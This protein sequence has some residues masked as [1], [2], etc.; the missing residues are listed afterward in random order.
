MNDS[1]AQTKLP[2]VGNQRVLERAVCVPFLDLDPVHEALSEEILGD[3]RALMASGAFTNGTQVAEFEGEFA[4]YCG[5]L[6]CVGVASG[7]DALRLALVAAGIQPGDEVVVPALTFAATFEAVSQ[8][9]GR[10]VVVDVGEGDYCM[11]SEEIQASISPRTRFLMPVHLYGQMADIAALTEVAARHDL[12]I[13]EDACQAHGAVRDGRRAG[14]AGVAGAFSFYPAKN[15]GAMG[16]AGA[17][18]TSDPELVE[19][20]RA[21]REHG[22]LAKYG[23]ELVGYTSRLDT[24]QALVLLRKLPFL[25]RW[26]NERR[27]AARFYSESLAGIGDLRLPPVAE[28]SDPVWHLY[29]VRTSRRA[30]LERFLSDRGIGSGRHYPQPPHLSAAYEGLGLRSGAFPLSEALAGEV[31]SLPIFPGISERQLETVAAAIVAFF[32]RG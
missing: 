1:G 8:A 21:L 24:I 6:F 28:G 9:G 16:D 12:L 20:V 2:S 18:V 10:P 14:T 27:Q 25:D 15:L 30:G 7:L 29:V 4:R 17:V 26:N 31:L 22:Q 11:E 13:V 3:I 32:Q 5:T 19:R 23:H